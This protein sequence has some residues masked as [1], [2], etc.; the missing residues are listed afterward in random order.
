VA[1]A[2]AQLQRLIRT[3]MRTGAL[4]EHRTFKC[5]LASRGQWLTLVDEQVDAL[6]TLEAALAEDRRFEYMKT[7]AIEE[8][9]WRFACRAAEQP[10]GDQVTAFVEKHATE[11]QTLTCFFP[12]EGL[13][14][15]REVDVSGATLT[16]AAAIDV[17]DLVFGPDPR[18]TMD[19]VIGVQCMGTSN[20]AM[21]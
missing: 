18:A 19:S 21:M 3:E 13:T 11:P 4:H 8:E 15:H 9:A 16:P 17:P 6:G 2:L 12:V 5:A 20:G 7:R 14:V 10:H 1:P